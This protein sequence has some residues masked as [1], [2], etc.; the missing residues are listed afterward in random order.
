MR[1]RRNA[2]SADLQYPRGFYDGRLSLPLG[3]FGGLFP[4]RIH[5][6]EPLAVLVK[7]SHLPV[8]VFPPPIFPK[9]GAFSCG[10]CF[11][12]GVNISMAIRARKY[13]FGQYFAHNR[14]I[15]HYRI[16]C[17]AERQVTWKVK[18]LSRLPV[19]LSHN[20]FRKI[21]QC[22]GLI[23]GGISLSCNRPGD[24]PRAAKQPIRKGPNRGFSRIGICESS[25]IQVTFVTQMNTI[26][27]LEFSSR[28]PQRLISVG[29]TYETSE[30]ARDGNPG[31]P[32]LCR[33]W[34]LCQLLTKRSRSVSEMR[35][36]YSRSRPQ[37]L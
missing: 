9:L 34:K 23:A 10:F 19:R 2:G 30:R 25:R 22:S 33:F 18:N 26:T 13:Q 29:G 7:H 27:I 11:G 17:D 37:R 24:S 28:P 3:E 35:S 8:L 1:A 31:I 21:S 5:T 6:S 14:I 20:V 4:V 15:L 12:H 36:S 16:G 32:F